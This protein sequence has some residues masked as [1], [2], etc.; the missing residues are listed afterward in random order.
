[1]SSSPSPH[2][3][4]SAAGKGKAVAQDTVT[5]AKDRR[6]TQ[7]SLAQLLGVSGSEA[8][9]VTLTLNMSTAAA[10]SASAP[11]PANRETAEVPLANHERPRA[12]KRKVPEGPRGR[13]KAVRTTADRVE[14]HQDGLPLDAVPGPG[15][16][17]VRR[18]SLLPAMQD[19]AA[20]HQEQHRD[21]LGDQQT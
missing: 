5:A 15:P 9:S 7:V 13:A 17:V 8:S 2:A 20:Q 21:A 16:E 19:D 3:A 14:E 6:M 10:S 18:I 1:M 12:T 11:A 4:R